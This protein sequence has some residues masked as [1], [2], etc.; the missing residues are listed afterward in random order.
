MLNNGAR[1]HYI[2]GNSTFYGVLVPVEQIYAEMLY[3]LGF[4][5]VECV[6]IRKRNS[7]K[8]LIKGALEV[9]RFFSEPSPNSY[10]RSS[11]I[12]SR[13]IRP[14][15]ARYSSVPSSSQYSVSMGAA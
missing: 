3:Q 2:V 9:I 11:T 4:F 13:S 12:P 15:I 8:E 10:A 5:N 6:P 14:N 1:I 7:K